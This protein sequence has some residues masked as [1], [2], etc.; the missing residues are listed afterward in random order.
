MHQLRRVQEGL[1]RDAAAVQAGAAQLL[2]LDDRNPEAKLGSSDGADIPGGAATDDGYV[3]R[4][5]GQ[6]PRFYP[7]Y[8]CQGCGIPACLAFRVAGFPHV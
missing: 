5:I 1:R 8:V 4:L 3:E 6:T 7:P 2:L